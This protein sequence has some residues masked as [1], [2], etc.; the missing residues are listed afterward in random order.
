VLTTATATPNQTRGSR[1]AGT[2]RGSVIMKN[3]KMSTS[4]D[5]TSTHQ[6]C[7]SHTGVMDHSAVMQR[8]ASARLAVHAAK[9]SQNAPAISSSPSRSVMRSPPSKARP[10]HSASPRSYADRAR[11]GSDVRARRASSRSASK[12]AASISTPP[13]RR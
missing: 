12:M 6:K 13:F 3:R 11:S 1:P 2:V 7:Q 8:P 9:V 4:G 5:V 10:R